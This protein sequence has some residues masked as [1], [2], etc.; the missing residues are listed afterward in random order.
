MVERLVPAV[1]LTEALTLGTSG[2]AVGL[3]IGSPLAGVL[4]DTY[5]AAAGYWIVV[6]GALMTLLLATVGSATLRRSLVPDDHLS[7]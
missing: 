3:A 5:G 7:T 1:R 6:A 2:I 4:I